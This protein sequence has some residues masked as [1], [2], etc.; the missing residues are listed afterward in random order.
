[1]KTYLKYL[2]DKYKACL[3]HVN[4]RLIKPLVSEIKGFLYIVLPVVNML[5]TTTNYLKNIYILLVCLN[6]SFCF[7]EISAQKELENCEWQKYY[8]TDN[9]LSSEG[10]FINGIP[11][12]VWK[13]YFNSGKLKSVGFRNESKLEGIWK[14]YRENSILEKEISYSG[15]KKDGREIIYYE[16]GDI[17]SSTNWKSGIKQGKE[18][19]YYPEGNIQ[20]MIKFEENKKHGKSIEYAQTGI[21]IGFTTYKK[22]L[23]TSIEKFNRYNKQGEKT[24][25]WKEFHQNETVKEEGP[26]KQNLK[27]GVFR[28]YNQ[29]GDLQDIIRYELGEKI[30]NDNDLS[31]TEIIITFHENGSKEE[32]TA[33][34]NGIKN[35]V[36]RTFNKSGEIILGSTFNEGKLISKG[37]IDKS[38]LEQGDWKLYYNDESIKSEGEYENGL[39]IGKWIFYN[40]K[41]WIEQTGSYIQGNLDGKWKLMDESGFIIRSEEYNKGLEDG[42]FKE[43]GLNKDLILNGLYKDGRRMGFWMYHVND[44]IEEGNYLNGEFDGKWIHRYSEG[45]KMFEGGYSF[46]Q[47]EGSHK[48]WYADGTVKASGKY[49]GGAKHG[50]WRY[51]SQNGEIDYI[52]LFRHDKL[53]KVD[54]RKVA[55]NRDSSRP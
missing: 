32:E 52:Y 33:Y 16:N 27:Q 11:E 14:F 35:G 22:G 29:R 19:Y 54:G 26:F 12:G 55:R 20:Y 25:I 4:Y 53:W 6:L 8:F 10:C 48:Y 34:K 23:V 38:G 39:R 18:Y 43:F 5:T 30:T 28:L 17:L 3:K 37:I 45:E 2:T 42:E 31:E 50:K 49:E 44:H 1:M 46:G 47:P 40:S 9:K 15:D 51:F 13:S 41:G 24:G 21:K 36:S 7:L